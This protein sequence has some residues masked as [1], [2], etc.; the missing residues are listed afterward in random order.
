MPPVAVVMDSTG[1]LPK[2]L[3][4]EYDI[5]IVSLYVN[6]DGG[7][8]TERESALLERLDTFYDEIRTA[9][10]WPTTSQPSLGDFIEVYEPLLAAGRDVVSI[11]ISSGISG[12]FDTAR[13]AAEALEREGKGGERVHVVDSGRS[14]GG[15]GLIAL[16]AATVAR[17]GGDRD[18]VVQR[19]LEAKDELRMWFA[20][21]RD[22]A[23]G[24][25][26]NVPARVRADGRLRAPAARLGRR[27]LGRTAHPLARRGDPPRRGVP[28]DL[29]LRPRVRIRDR[30]GPRC[31]HGPGAARRRRHPAAAARGLSAA[32]SMRSRRGRRP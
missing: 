31:A 29:R 2:E 30:A 17:G 4:A 26:T 15:L 7:A 20:R 24:A 11:H 14:A 9:E 19:A 10:L 32:S 28:R 23:R 18:A 12:T 5:Q 8:R 3:A 21:P 27:R 22:R 1:Y 6:L 13:Q 16:A 25:G